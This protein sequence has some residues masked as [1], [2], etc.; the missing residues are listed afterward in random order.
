M[1][2]LMRSRNKIKTVALVTVSLVCIV[3]V[4]V[5]LRNMRRLELEFNRKRAVLVRENLDLKDRIDSTEK[6]LALRTEDLNALERELD[7]TNDRM[8]EI[9]RTSSETIS[10][11]S[12]EVEELRERKTALEEELSSLRDMTVIQHLEHSAEKEENPGVKALL[13]RTIEIIG[14]IM[15]GE[16]VSLAPVMVTAPSPGQD[17]QDLI[18]FPG[19]A[20]GLVLSTD[21]RNNLIVTNLGRKDGVEENSTCVVTRDNGEELA[22]GYVISVRYRVSA[23]FIDEVKVG[24]TIKD[25]SESD[26]VII[27]SF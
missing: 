18:T 9:E 8:E 5:T 10:S 21:H 4:A 25:I 22:R 24:R 17:G 1:I 26:K 27:G 15:D 6:D 12:Q 23:V 3:A 7:L 11:F 16:S 2:R 14:M 19:E 13:Q 20:R